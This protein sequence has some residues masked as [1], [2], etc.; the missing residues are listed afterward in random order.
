VLEK[1]NLDDHQKHLSK[2]GVYPKMEDGVLM[3][4][5][6]TKSVSKFV[7]KGLVNCLLC[8]VNEMMNSCL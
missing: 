2:R 1:E 6:Y 3:R 8:S 4:V 5:F 7:V